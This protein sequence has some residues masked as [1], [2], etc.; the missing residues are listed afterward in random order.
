VVWT[1]YCGTAAKAGGNRENKLRPVVM[2]VSCLLEQDNTSEAF[3][4]CRSL[5]K[6][7][8]AMI[9]THILNKGDAKIVR[10]TLAGF[11]QSV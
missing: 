9:Y 6:V 11:M 2:G 7:S 10:G 5:K 3:M 1:R 8:T 4:N